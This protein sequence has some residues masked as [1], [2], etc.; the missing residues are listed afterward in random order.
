MLSGLDAAGKLWQR[1][2]NVALL[3]ARRFLVSAFRLIDLT[4]Y[5]HF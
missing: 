5:G 2:L 3:L 1:V 4:T